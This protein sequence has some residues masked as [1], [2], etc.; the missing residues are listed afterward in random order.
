MAARAR[1]LPGRVGGP[2][3]PLKRRDTDIQHLCGLEADLFPVAGNDIPCGRESDSLWQGIRFPIYRE[4]RGWCG[5]Q[6][7]GRGHGPLT[8]PE[9][10]QPQPGSR[11][12]AKPAPAPRASRRRV[13]GVQ[14][15]SAPLPKPQG[16]ELEMMPP[17]PGR[18]LDLPGGGAAEGGGTPA[19]VPRR[20]RRFQHPREIKR[21]ATGNQ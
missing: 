5:P 7:A 19:G 21:G 20:S 8:R 9:H 6:P 1:F 14:R 12:R 15:G 3:P 17:A 16:A 10:P 11:R 18:G 4:S 13:R 2:D